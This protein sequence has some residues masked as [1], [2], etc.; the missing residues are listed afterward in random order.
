MRPR[1]M[2]SRRRILLWRVPNPSLVPLYV[3]DFPRNLSKPRLKK[4]GTCL[5]E[6]LP[7]SGNRDVGAHSL[8]FHDKVEF[9]PHPPAVATKFYCNAIPKSEGTTRPP[10][11]P[12]PK[13]PS[14][15]KLTHVLALLLHLVISS[16]SLLCSS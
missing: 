16:L 12:Q 3:S 10:R 15:S 2:R 14:P 1:S 8:R 5:G 6:K 11:P 9:D 13:T 4:F 7:P